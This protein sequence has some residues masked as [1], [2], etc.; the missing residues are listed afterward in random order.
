MI[1]DPDMRVGTAIRPQ[2]GLGRAWAF[3]GAIS[4]AGCI[5][6]SQHLTHVRPGSWNKLYAMV[7]KD[8]GPGAGDEARDYLQNSPPRPQCED[9]LSQLRES[10]YTGLT[11]RRAAA[12]LL[13][14]ATVTSAT[15]GGTAVTRRRRR[16]SGCLPGP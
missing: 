2:F 4:R 13:K 16:R 6:S 1:V 9:S 10:A 15:R 14:V 7:R 12:G 3:R 5:S 8:L 11:L